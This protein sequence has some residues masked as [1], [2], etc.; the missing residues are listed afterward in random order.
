MQ[1]LRDFRHS[2]WKEMYS[3]RLLVLMIA[4]FLW[5]AA[6]ELAWG[7]DFARSSAEAN[8]SHEATEQAIERAFEVLAKGTRNYPEHRQCFSCHHQA[9]PL[10]AFSSATKWQDPSTWNDWRSSSIVEAIRTFSHE[11]FEYKKE[12]MLQGGGVGGKSLT[13][14]YGLWML[15]VAGVEPN[16]TTDAMV[17]YLLQNQA[18][19]G[20]WDFQSLRPPASSSRAM[21]SAVSLL[22]LRAYASEVLKVRFSSAALKASAWIDTLE[23]SPIESI[24]TEELVGRLWIINLLL[25]WKE[26]I[27]YSNIQKDFKM[28]QA[29]ER[30]LALGTKL[31]DQLQA[32]QNRDGSWSQTTQMAG[33]AYATGQALLML[34][35]TSSAIPMS[36]GKAFHDSSEFSEGIEYLLRTQEA[37]GSW[38]VVT[39]SKPVQVYFDNGDPHGKDQFLSMMATSWGSAA[40]ANSLSKNTQ[41][42]ESK[43]RL[44]DQQ[45]SG[46]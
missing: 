33:D 10:F 34:V 14:G 8:S 13:V 6:C 12:T 25:D 20:G 24:D 31:R 21:A 7:E 5:F 28:Q 23:S 42:L 9:L 17:E 45:K 30:L 44:M 18:S 38:H 1:P 32:R 27:D 39:R 11:S 36:E 35:E 16:P 15:D 41:P 4:S 3:A 22:G 19:D 29:R 40:L 26:A 2:D 43:R 46:Q 37:D